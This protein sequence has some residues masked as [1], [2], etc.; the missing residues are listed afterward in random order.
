MTINE[1][2]IAKLIN[3]GKQ[4]VN[5]AYYN[6][7]DYFKRWYTGLVSDFHYYNVKLADGTTAVKEK[8]T[9]NLAKKVSE[10]MCKLLWSNKVQINLDNPEKTTQLWEILEANNFNVMMPRQLELCAALGTVAFSEF[11]HE[12]NVVIE[13]LGDPSRIIPFS[14]C[15]N[16]ITG[17][18]TVN[19]FTRVEGK[20]I[21]YY[22]HLV[23]HEYV[24]HTYI[25]WNAVYKSDTSTELGNQISFNTLFP[26]V[27]ESII[28]ED[29]DYPHF[30][31]L[32]FPIVNNY[33]LDNPLGLSVYGNSI[34]R[35]K[36]LD[37]KYDSF[38]NEFIS[39]KKRILID[40]SA[41]KGTPQVDS[42]G[43][44]TTALYFDKNDTTYVAL[45]GMEDQPIK[46]ID[47]KLRYQEHVESI[48]A[49]LN[50]LSSNVGFGENFY[51]FGGSHHP[52]TATEV[53]SR[54][55]DAYRTKENY[56]PCVIQV[57]ENLVRS[58]C[59]LAGIEMS[60][61]EIITDYSRF[62]NDA[63]EQVR[64]ME[65]VN[66]GI[67]SKVEYRIKIYNEDEQI[68][69]QKIQEIESK[70]PNIEELMANEEANI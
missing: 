33:D 20:D 50:W 15:N 14:Y 11:L 66:A 9:M 46:E 34:D 35:F 51:S 70:E 60:T 26:D 10:D 28:Y 4:G 22:T 5:G 43:N 68:A 58:V 67:T 18:V 64:L 25:K 31:I 12:G 39:G 53:I 63:A 47:F 49:E 48:Q 21:I 54:D 27:Q 6:Q 42:S 45:R 16:Q 3:Q 36:G 32:K 65:E 41:L 7:I 69:Q 30:Q 59:Y 52:V 37:T 19:P 2:I 61:I 1:Q 23:F 40:A 13:Y 57:L 29:V 62:K 8:M 44:V 38:N 55:S 56:D 17:F 24:D